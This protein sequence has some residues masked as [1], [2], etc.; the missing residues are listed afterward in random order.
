MVGSYRVR[1]HVHSGSC[2]V[3][4]AVVGEV[5]EDLSRGEGLPRGDLAIMAVSGLIPVWRCQVGAWE[6]RQPGA[7]LGRSRQ[8]CAGR[9]EAGQVRV[10]GAEVTGLLWH[11]ASW[12]L[13][14]AG[15]GAGQQVEGQPG[16]LWCQQRKHRKQ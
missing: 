12:S 2:F 13:V 4:W 14:V 7:G 3:V 10:E 9:A 6:L 5:V 1:I 8:Q 16:Q 15:A 11:P